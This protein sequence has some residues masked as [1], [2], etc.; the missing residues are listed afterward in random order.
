MSRVAE[1]SRS[2]QP[3]L[4]TDGSSWPRRGQGAGGHGPRHGALH[5]LL[6]IS[7]RV[8]SYSDRGLLGIATDKDFAS[9]GYLYLLYVYE[10][11]PLV[12]DSSGPMVSRLTRVTVNP[13]NTLENPSD[14]E[15]VILGKDVSGPCPEPDNTRDCI[16]ADYKWHV[17]GTVRSDPEDGTLWVGTGDTHA[18]LVDARSYRPYDES[19]FAGKIIHVERNGQGLSD[20]PFCS[21]DT[22]LSH[23]CTKLYAKG[24][25]N[26]FRFSVRSGKGPVVGDVGSEHREELD[27]LKPGRNYGWPCYGG[28]SHSALRPGDSLPAGVR[29]GGHRRR[30]CEAGLE[31]SPRDRSLGRGRSR[32]YRDPLPSGV[33]GQRL[34]R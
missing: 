1:A 2:L 17:I 9:N 33:S 23:T 31:L 15:T 12:P 26:P 6:D 7:A 5:P 19:T 16:P 18:P 27:L 21:A 4:R 11:D 28:R 3:S 30:G 13:D 29:E 14:P 34:R 25:R 10:L 22:N 8:N 20:H 32:V 24:F